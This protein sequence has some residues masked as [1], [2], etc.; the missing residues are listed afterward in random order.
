M[1]IR[2]LLM[3]CALLVAAGT[4][5]GQNGLNMPYSQY[6]V[7]ESG[8]PFNMPFSMGMGGAVYTLS[9][10]NYVNPFNPASYASVQKETFVFDMGLNIQ[11][12][13]LKDASASLYDADGNIG[14]LAVAFPLTKWWKTSVGL[15][16]GTDMSYASSKIDSTEGGAMKTIYDGMGGVSQAY[17]GHAFNIGKRLSVGM[18]MNY[19]FGSIGRQIVYDFQGNDSTYWVDSYRRK[20]STIRSLFLDLGLQYR[21]PLGEKYTLGLG[22]VCKLP[23]ASRVTDVALVATALGDTIFPLPGQENTYTS[24]LEQPLTL[25]AGLSLE[26]NNRW[27]VAADFTHAPWSGLKYTENTTYSLFGRSALS[28]GENSRFSLGFDY[29]GNK[30]ATQYIRRIGIRAGIHYEQGK[31]RLNLDGNDYC[32]NEFGMG[33]G[34]AFPMRKGQSVMNLSI[35]Y[36]HYGSLSPLMRNSVTIGISVGSCESWFVKRKYN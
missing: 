12:S 3:I 23:K 14:Y 29:K 6:G 32:L 16:P 33:A 22:L 11:M 7:G 13:R 5:R 15:M 18:N 28:Y 4:A 36:A 17:W 8:M 27:L 34:L 25:G 2:E 10:S 31:L 19:M 26:R 9:G 1:K 24:T 20:E 21:Q 35:H 30:D